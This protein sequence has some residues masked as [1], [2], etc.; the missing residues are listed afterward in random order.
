MALVGSESK[1]GMA[2]SLVAKKT[3]SKVPPDICFLLNFSAAMTE[4]PHCGSKPSA[5]P[6]G[7]VSR[8]LFLF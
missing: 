7:T 8:L 1:T 5:A 2:S 3:A 4:K 6:I